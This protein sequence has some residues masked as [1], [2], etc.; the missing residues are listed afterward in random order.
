M[1]VPSWEGAEVLELGLVPGLVALEE[2]P[3][4]CAGGYLRV[5]E[6]VTRTV[7][8]LLTL[9]PLGAFVHTSPQPSPSL[10]PTQGAVSRDPAVAVASPAPR[11]EAGPG[12]STGLCLAA[13]SAPLLMRSSTSQNHLQLL[14]LVWGF[15]VPGPFAEPPSRLP[16]G[17]SLPAVPR[18]SHA[19]SMPLSVRLEHSKEGTPS[20]SQ[21]WSDLPSCPDLLL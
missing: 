6:R 5:Q 9:R 8:Q 4:P 17:S 13:P 21:R 16:P 14:G 7:G 12:S 1:G 10:G 15:G 11:R 18:S 2:D 20:S 3:R 19:L